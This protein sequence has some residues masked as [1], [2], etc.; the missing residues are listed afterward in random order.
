MDKG[1]TKK[2]ISDIEKKITSFGWKIEINNLD[3]IN[4]DDSTWWYEYDEYAPVLMITKGKD[5]YEIIATG[6]ITITNPNDDEDY[7]YFRGGKPDFGKDELTESLVKNGDWGDNNWFEIIPMTKYKGVFKEVSGIDD[8]TD[9]SLK[10]I[11]S[12]LISLLEK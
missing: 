10:S 3:A 1:F 12:Q 4:K 9:I 2:E 6:D 11:I 7:F 8:F 5:G